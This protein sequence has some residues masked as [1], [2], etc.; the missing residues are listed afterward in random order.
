LQDK[1]LL[2]RRIGELGE[3]KEQLVGGLRATVDQLCAEQAE[4][5][6]RLRHAQHAAKQAS[7]ATQVLSSCP[8]F[9]NPRL[10]SG[11]FG[12]SLAYVISALNL[13]LS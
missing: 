7:G 3:E 13:R 2:A 1:A 11:F 10:R 4:L 6:A 5:H 9:V 12:S 8:C